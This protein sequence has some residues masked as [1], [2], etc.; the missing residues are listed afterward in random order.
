MIYSWACFFFFIVICFQ[1]LTTLEN[2]FRQLKW[3]KILCEL[4]RP[5]RL[6][7]KQKQKNCGSLSRDIRMKKLATNISIRKRKVEWKI[8]N[9]ECEKGVVEKIH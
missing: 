6:K 2:N 3:M 8:S 4:M 7:Q 9:M 1:I 5:T